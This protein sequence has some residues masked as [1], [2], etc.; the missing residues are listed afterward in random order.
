MKKL[1]EFSKV[2]ILVL[3]ILATSFTNLIA[4]DHSVQGKVISKE[5]GVGLPGVSV[6]VK[7]TT[8]GTVTD[9]TGSYKLNV[10][11]NAILVFSFVGYATEEVP[12]GNQSTID[13]SLVLDIKAL[14]EV[15]VV[16]YGTQ[17]KKDVTG[18]V[19]SVEGKT[20]AQIPT[21]NIE[22]ALQG[23]AAGVQI[24]SNSGQPGASSNIRIRGTGTIGN[25]NPLY[26]I[27]GVQQE[28]NINFLNSD[29]IATLDIL[30]DASA[31]AIYGSRGANGVIIITTKRGK[32][33]KG[34]LTFNAYVGTQSAWRTLDVTNASE[35]ATLDN[36]ARDNAGFAKN[37]D[38]ANPASLGEGTNWQKA[39]FRNAGI[40]NYQLAYSGGANKSTYYVSGSYLK[41]DGINIGTA[42]QRFNFR[43]NVDHQ[44]NAKLKFGNTLLLTHTVSDNTTNNTGFNTGVLER[45]IRQL[46]TVP[47]YNPDGSYAGPTGN[48][49]GE[50]ENPVWLAEQAFNRGRNYG[51]QGSLYGDYQILPGL[52]FR[53]T[54]NVNFNDYYNTDFNP[55]YSIGNRSNSTNSLTVSTGTAFGYQW[56]NTLN[57]L[58]SFDKHTVEVLAGVEAQ[59]YKYV[60]TSAVRSGFSKNYDIQYLDQGSSGD[61]ARGNASGYSLLSFLGRINYNYAGKY[62]LTANIRRDGSSKFAGANRYGVFPSLSGGWRISEESFFQSI[63]FISNL[64]LRGGWGQTGNQ[65]IGS[66]YPTYGVINPNAN[67]VFGTSQTVAAGYSQNTQVNPDIKWE[68]TT[69]SNVGIDVGFL[70]NRLTLTADYFIK[71]TDGILLQLPIP[72]STGVN[73]AFTNAGKI[74]NQGIELAINYA[75]STGAFT[76]NVGFNI[77]SIK[78]K[79]LDLKGLPYINDFSRTQEG[80][81]VGELYGYV[82]DGIF[83]NQDE[84]DKAA[85]QNPGAD[86]KTHTAPGDIRF[87]DLNGDGVIDASDRTFIGK[88]L[89]DFTAG[90]NAGFGYKGFDL[91]LSFNG[92]FGNKIYSAISVYNYSGDPGN[93]FKKLIG[94]T[95]SDTNKGAQYPRLIGGDPNSNQR[96]SDRFVN[97]ASF[98]RLKNI[99]LGYNFSQAMLDRIKLSKLRIYVSSANPFT[100]T[101]YK[102]GF[103][104]E[105][106]AA[107]TNSDGSANQL[108]VGIDR[109][110][111]PQAR[112]FLIG[113][114]VGL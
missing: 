97:D 49:S 111:Y 78:N 84:V 1:Y 14:S 93:K 7:G 33:G 2:S 102:D 27:D 55:S 34:Q 42:F 62:L 72:A 68:T 92:S 81:T 90:L 17:E 80:H 26:V 39:L 40:Q 56:S 112:T 9:V 41:Q 94:N 11:D 44:V 109:G 110:V 51:M 52:N 13:V 21:P 60:N 8:N 83:Q 47:I 38:W 87:K 59:E 54:I 63:P 65:N 114:N 45:G 57:Y 48:F 74:K 25:N 88:V 66:L 30:K 58:K 76:Y 95:W 86:P 19:S 23:K 4:Q 28:G 29:D 35:Y 98:I 113:I 46:P 24:T 69:Q 18:A 67:Y 106:G 103:D 96:V 64:K 104:P 3:V 101:K 6:V 12:V 75:K 37:P 36:L 5:E 82:T 16:G 31:T 105:Q 108:D 85:K 107:L 53:S 100:W 32:V 91:S 89:P 20:L 71:N 99:Q 70:E 77:T 61:Q 50:S 10:G 79:V 73:P 15:V 22:Q 43:V